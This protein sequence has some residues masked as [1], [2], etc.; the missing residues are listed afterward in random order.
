MK[1]PVEAVGSR[2][3]YT[4]TRNVSRLNFE[5]NNFTEKPKLDFQPLTA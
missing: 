5:P 2:H 1:V 4:F 3:V